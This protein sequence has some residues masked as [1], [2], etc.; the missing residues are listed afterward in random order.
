M[1]TGLCFSLYRIFLLMFP[2]DFR[3]EYAEE[4]QAIFTEALDEARHKG[5][6]ALIRLTLGELGGLLNA[7]LRQQPPPLPHSAEKPEIWV[8]PPS[9]QE[10]L[11]VFAIFVL[12]GLSI[13]FNLPVEALS[14]FLGIML[15]GV[16]V[17]ALLKGFQR[18]TLPAIGL[19]I[20]AFSFIFLFQWAADLVTPAMLSDLG[21]IPKDESTRL[22][23]HAFWAGLMWFSLFGFTFM[24]LGV[25]SLVRRFRMQLVSIWQD[26]TLASYILYSGAVFTLMITF[27]QYRYEKAYALASTLCLATGAWLYLRSARQW[28]RTL[29]LLTGMTLAMGAIAASQWPAANLAEWRNLFSW[30]PSSSE[31]GFEAHRVLL[32]WAWMTLILLAPILLKLIPRTGKRTGAAI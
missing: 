7:A 21:I 12:P 20:S 10:L 15:V 24:I 18:W 14:V 17:A 2:A 30:S 1:Q 5:Q 27:D 11:L 4:M 29:A 32:D 22:L 16:F 3:A 9:R 19:G 26:W 13:W 8:G 6:L 28:Q 31:S 23:L 25:L